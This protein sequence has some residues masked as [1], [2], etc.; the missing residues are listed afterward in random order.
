MAMNIQWN[1]PQPTDFSGILQSNLANKQ[2]TYDELAKNLGNSIRNTHDYML[3]RDLANMI[4]NNEGQLSND[5]LEK[6]IVANRARRITKDDSPLIQWRWQKEREDAVNLANQK[7][8]NAD[9]ESKKTMEESLATADQEI[10]DTLH[11]I[12]MA[13][14]KNDGDSVQEQMYVLGKQ[15]EA[16]NKIADMVGKPHFE[17]PSEI[18]ENQVDPSVDLARKI[19]YQLND[20]SLTLERKQ[21]LYTEAMN[22]P[23]GSVKEKLIA[24]F[25][26]IKTFDEERIHANQNNA[27]SRQIQKNN[28]KDDANRLTFTELMSKSSWTQDELNALTSKFKTRLNED[29]VKYGKMSTSEK[30]YWKDNNKNEWTFLKERGMI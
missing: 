18:T 15:I 2:K 17:I 10:R 5:E 30:K 11:E 27:I 9:L 6:Q 28:S 23:E 29:A 14:A 13:R 7:K 24:K 8:A 25:P 4:D 12:R 19:E 22:L 3:D 26:T 1:F 20:P 21:E 16:R